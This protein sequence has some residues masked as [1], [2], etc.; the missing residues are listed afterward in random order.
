MTIGKALLD[1]GET[2]NAPN[3]IPHLLEALRYASE[4]E[5]VTDLIGGALD[6]LIFA[7]SRTPSTAALR[8]L[9]DW[10]VRS[11][12]AIFIQGLKIA[13]NWPWA[14]AKANAWTE[15]LALAQA[16]PDLLTRTPTPSWR[17]AFR[18]AARPW[19]DAAEQ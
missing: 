14:V 2:K 13:E 6:E 5:D 4:S 19:V 12:E 3:A 8:A 18:Q 9:K 10:L 1:E 7:A 11:P 15:A 16:H 17:G